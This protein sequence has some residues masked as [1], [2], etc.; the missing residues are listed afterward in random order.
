MG[1]PK[2]PKYLL[3]RPGIEFSKLNQVFK[4]IGQA[5]GQVKISLL[6]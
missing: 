2:L 3:Y 5:A 1:G 4:Y 6:L